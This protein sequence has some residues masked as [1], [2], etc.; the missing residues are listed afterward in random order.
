MPE[1]MYIKKVCKDTDEKIFDFSGIDD[2]IKKID[3]VN[4]KDIIKLFSK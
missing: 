4:R 2:D 1:I 3:F